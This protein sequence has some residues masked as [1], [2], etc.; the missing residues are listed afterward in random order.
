MLAY[1]LLLLLLGAELGLRAW[2]SHRF[3]AEL[4][5]DPA[6]QRRYRER[7]AHRPQ[8]DRRDLLGPARLLPAPILAP[9]G[10]PE[11][12]TAW[13]TWA[14]LPE[15]AFRAPPPDRPRV[16]GEL[17]V[18]LLG[19]TL[20]WDG[21][22]E[23]L[24]A[25]ATPAQKGREVRVA[26][27]A[28]PTASLGAERVLAR[29][30][31]VRWSPGLIV[32]IP[33]VD[34]VVFARLRARVAGNAQVPAAPA[35]SR[36]I[37]HLLRD[38]LRGKAQPVLVMKPELLRE[39]LDAAGALARNLGAPLLLVAAPRDFGASPHLEREIRYLFPVLGDLATLSA[40]LGGLAQGPPDF[41]MVG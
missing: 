30:F 33:S 9:G 36:G 37:L 13:R 2:S 24:E 1:S 35:R 22:A 4:A 18:A 16:E 7:L 28:L 26:S 40:E 19:D 41:L 27:L 25:V 8:L 39:P 5:K 29:R 23:A 12:I 6:L 34:A 10:D 14:S 21:L 3:E 38:A 15:S 11:A 17:R 31:L 20:A 32:W